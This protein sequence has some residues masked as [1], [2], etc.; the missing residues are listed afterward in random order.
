[1]HCKAQIIIIIIVIILPNS[2]CTKNLKLTVKEKGH[3]QEN[4]KISNEIK[5]M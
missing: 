2:N 1:M 5:R 3:K 4:K